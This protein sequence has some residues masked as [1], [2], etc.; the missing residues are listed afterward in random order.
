MEILTLGDSRLR[1][2]AA[3]VNVADLPQL[4]PLIDQLID[5]LQGAAGIGIAAPQVGHNLQLLILAS[6]PN[7]RYPD[8]PLMEPTPLIN[9]QILSRSADQVLGW[10]G[11]LSVPQ[12]RGQVWRDRSVTVAYLN[13]QGQPRQ[14]V[15]TDFIARIFQHEYDHLLGKVFLDRID[16]PAQLI[17]EADYRQQ[18]RKLSHS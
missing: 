10:E 17:S 14:Q 18:H 11:C 5:Q 16:D 12:Q 15:F 3:P 1:R 2:V 8:A 9:P 7:R 6:H 13:R 4:Q